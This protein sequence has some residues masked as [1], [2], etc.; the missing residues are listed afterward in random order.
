MHYR[1]NPDCHP[2]SGATTHLHP[3]GCD[4]TG[5]YANS[6]AYRHASSRGDNGGECRA[7][8]V[9]HGDTPTYPNTNAGTG[10]H[11]NSAPD[12]YAYA[13]RDAG[14][15][16]YGNALPH[17]DAGSVEPNPGAYPPAPDS[18]RPPNAHGP[19]LT[20]GWFRR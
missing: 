12:S 17:R 16:A 15:S 14:A 5:N 1:R 2:R 9:A 11:G 3:G 8:I 4:T 19:S 13:H 18:G 20:P 7:H 6:D 10:G